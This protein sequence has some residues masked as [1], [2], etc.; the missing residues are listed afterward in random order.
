MEFVAV[1]VGNRRPTAFVLQTA[2]SEKTSCFGN[3]PVNSNSQL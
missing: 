3:Q 2:A 1:C